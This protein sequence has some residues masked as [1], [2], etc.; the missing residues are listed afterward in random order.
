[1]HA[2]LKKN[3]QALKLE[4]KIL[5]VDKDRALRSMLKYTL[6]LEHFEVEEA[7]ECRE[8]FAKINSGFRPDLIISGFTPPGADELAFL[9]AV[10][11][12]PDFRYI[13][14]LMLVSRPDLNK[15]MEW[16]DAGATCWLVKPF[17]S[18]QLME[19]VI[20]VLFQKKEIR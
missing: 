8:A 13:P 11:G 5:V 15:Q 17:T 9:K 16:R 18:D 14:V 1:M 20:M 2:L 10:R 19:M 6:C 12:V 7:K 4:K 3:T